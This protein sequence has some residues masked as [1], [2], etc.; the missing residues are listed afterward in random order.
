[1]KE[2]KKSIKYRE[3]KEFIENLPTFQLHKPLTEKITFRKTM[4]SYTDQQWQADLVDM[5]TFE[6]ENKGYRYILTVIDIFSRY[7][8]ALPIK[9]KR[10]EDVRDAFKLIFKEAKPEKIQFDD[11]KEFYNKLFKELLEANEIEWFSTFSDKKATV[12]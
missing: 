7:A 3:L 1:M 10:R 2:D 6:K 11:G 4:V 5:Q 9:S 8:W 12:V